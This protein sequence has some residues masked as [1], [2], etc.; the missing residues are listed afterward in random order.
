MGSSIEK[1]SAHPLTIGNLYM[2]EVYVKLGEEL[3]F[4]VGCQYIPFVALP[5]D[6]WTELGRTYGIH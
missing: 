2:E 6:M 4:T 3:R 5:L 1:V